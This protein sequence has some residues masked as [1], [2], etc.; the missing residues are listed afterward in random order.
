[1]A[2]PR[3]KSKT[4]RVTVNLDEHAYAILLAIA[5]REDVPVA[6]IARKAVSDLIQREGLTIDQ[7]TLP[8]V[9]PQ[10]NK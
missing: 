6:Q 1:M 10:P 5:R 7:G 2:R 9:R 3:G 4:A 8:L